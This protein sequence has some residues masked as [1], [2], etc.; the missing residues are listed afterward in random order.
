MKRTCI[1]LMIGYSI[2][3]SGWCFTAVTTPQTTVSGN[4]NITPPPPPAMQSS[5]FN[6][7]SPAP[8]TP[9][10]TSAS[11][12]TNA[13]SKAMPAQPVASASTPSTVP[14]AQPVASTQ[15]PVMP[16]S[17]ATLPNSLQPTV[18]QPT[19]TTSTVPA[20]VTTP[21]VS[22]TTKSATAPAISTLSAAPTTVTAATTTSK[23]ISTN[24]PTPPM[25][26]SPT[27]TTPTAPAVSTST[28]PFVHGV[29][30]DDVSPNM[31]ADDHD[32]STGIHGAHI[33]SGINFESTE[34]EDTFSMG[35]VDTTHV[36]HVSGNW[37]EK[38]HY[39]HEIEDIL[40]QVKEKIADIGT[41]RT[42]F[43]STRSEV[44]KELST[45]YQ[46]VGLDQGPL[47]D[48]IHY[49]LEIMEK[50]KEQQGFL[51]R[52]ERAFYDKAQSKQRVFE[53]LK[54]D[55]KAIG[56]VDSKMDE[57]LDV[58]LK[59]VNTCNE[60]E[61][62]V[63][64]IYKTVAYELSE[65]EAE[66]NYLV[67]KAFLKDIENIQLYLS[68][69]FQTYFQELAESVQTHTQNIV[70]Q[71][72]GLEKDGLSLKKEAAK[73]EAEEEEIEQEAAKHM[74]EVKKMQESKASS[75][76]P[77]KKTKQDTQAKAS[78]KAVKKSSVMSYFT[79]IVTSVQE[80]CMKAFG[81]VTG[82]F[83]SSKNKKNTPP[84]A[85]KPTVTS[86]KSS[87]QPITQT[88]TEPEAAH[89]A[90]PGAVE[91]EAVAPEHEEIPQWKKEL[92]YD[93]QR[94]AQEMEE[95]KSSIAA[96]SEEI[97]REPEDL[98]HTLQKD[99]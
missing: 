85:K 79:E 5:Y 43:F 83:T 56:V 92:Q 73:F 45:F 64:N 86:E 36:K 3:V 77:D 34:D 70:M 59:Q 90:A 98:F 17:P 84:V 2:I 46:H 49:A 80:G 89:H 88:T 10:T 91:Q 6:S 96:K 39:W 19:S 72:D 44:D 40:D 55:I 37:V 65:K 61:G 53:Q 87:T 24:M 94:F 15:P 68:G 78:Q 95:L 14:S 67:A 38:K 71:L 4:K 75:V 42:T 81:W 29:S 9:A 28:T 57:A 30:E 27:A 21:P 41:Q 48:M 25:P 23:S 97:M 99:L 16:V 93:E 11:T 33:T 52:K 47:Q 35:G 63:W 20:T 51:N 7:T 8:S 22:S 1:K 12:S 31:A 18:T 66:Q 26:P 54:E 58:V 76:A 32:A 60:Y 13:V 50:E 74:E 69:P 62:E 82:L